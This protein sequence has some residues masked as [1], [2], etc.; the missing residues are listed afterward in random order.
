MQIPSGSPYELEWIDQET[1]IARHSHYNRNLANFTNPT[2]TLN[3]LVVRI[4][5]GNGV[6]PTFDAVKLE[7]DIFLDGH[8][9]KS[10]FSACSYESLNIQQATEFSS[11]VN[12][13]QVNGVVD[14]SVDTAAANGNYE[15]LE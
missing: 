1:D 10:Q 12:G 15:I 5:D 2:G 9:L 4:V 8:S 11:T 6:S 14:I 13:I 3:T 7:D